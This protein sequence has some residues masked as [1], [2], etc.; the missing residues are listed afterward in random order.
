EGY[1]ATTGGLRTLAESLTGIQGLAFAY[2]PG[3]DLID[4]INAAMDAMI[5]DGTW[6]DIYRAWFGS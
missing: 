5:A 2:P 1:I 4:P 3:S 6:D